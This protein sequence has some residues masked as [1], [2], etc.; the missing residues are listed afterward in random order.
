MTSE[1]SA[2]VALLNLVLLIE[3]TTAGFPFKSESLL[4]NR[5]TD[6]AAM[7]TVASAHLTSDCCPNDLSLTNLSGFALLVRKDCYRNR[8]NS[9]AK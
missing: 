8:H 1:L 4:L 5:C 6:I 7:C 9:F 3:D 2:K